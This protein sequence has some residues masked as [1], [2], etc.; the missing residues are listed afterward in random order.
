MKHLHLCEYNKVKALQ[1]LDLNN[2]FDYDEE[3]LDSKMGAKKIE[4]AYKQAESRARN[5][6]LIMGAKKETKAPTKHDLDDPNSKLWSRIDIA[7]FNDGIKQFGKD[8][9]KIQKIHVNNKTK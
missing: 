8:F 4:Q 6:L 9:H 1:T 2:M 3:Y 5:D 7:K